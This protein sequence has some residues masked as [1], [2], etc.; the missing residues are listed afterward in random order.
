MLL[1]VA[2]QA[3]AA[4]QDDEARPALEAAAQAR[5]GYLRVARPWC[6]VKP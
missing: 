2:V 1:A 5:H 3:K 6:T 4:A